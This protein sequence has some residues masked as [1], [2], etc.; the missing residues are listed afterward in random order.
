MLAVP[1][2]IAGENFQVFFPD[3]VTNK[4]AI[5]QF[6]QVPRPFEGL[7]VLFVGLSEALR[8]RKG[9]GM[10]SHDFNALMHRF[11]QFPQ[12]SLILN[13]VLCC[14]FRRGARGLELSALPASPRIRTW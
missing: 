13:P 12:G 10:F 5:N 2:F 3:D 14:T 7:L 8:A 6:Q 9:W 1:G 4:L 11:L